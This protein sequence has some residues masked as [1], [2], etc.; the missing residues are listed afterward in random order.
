MKILYI[1]T[2]LQRGGAEKVV[3]DLADAMLAKGCEVKIAYLKGPLLTKPKS[4]NIEL[5]N[6][7]LSKF[8]DLPKAYINL[9]KLINHYQPDIVHSHMVHANILSRLVRVSTPID[10]LICSAHSS[11]EGGLIRMLSYRLTNSLSDLTTNVS[12]SAVEIFETRKAIPRNNMKYVYNGVDFNLFKYEPNARDI[13]RSN[14]D[15]DDDT[16]II[17]AVGRLNVAKNYPNLLAAVKILKNQISTPIKLLIAGDGELKTEI[18]EL[19]QTLD[20]SEEVS[21]LGNRKDIQKLM[22]ACDV[23]VLSSDYEGL[24]TVLIEALACECQIVSTDVSGAAEVLN[25]YG[26]IVPTNNSMELANAIE[27]QLRL[28]EKN[29]NGRAFAKRKFDLRV[30]T[31]QWLSIYTTL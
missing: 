21:L 4:K 27:E 8:T 9:S 22:S 26:R 14:L 6:I 19:V 28:T 3:C 18:N 2:G 7:N 24:P 30:V 5:F 12:K 1:I 25:I 29:I 15:I 16:K 10:K 13:I 17:L 11:N 20:L 31:E 23:F